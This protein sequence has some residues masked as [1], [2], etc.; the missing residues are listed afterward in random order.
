MKIISK[1]FKLIKLTNSIYFIF[2]EIDDMNSFDIKILENC[3]KQ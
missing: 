1:F 3:I 2:G